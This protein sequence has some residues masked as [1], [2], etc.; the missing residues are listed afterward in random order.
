MAITVT[1]DRMA[2][3]ATRWT[4]S[5]VAVGSTAVVACLL[6]WEL[7]ARGPL[8]DAPF[9]TVVEIV[10]SLLGLLATG[11]FWSSLGQT[12]TTALMGLALAIGAGVVLGVLLG[13]VEFAYR[14]TRL[15]I[16]ILKPIPPIVIMPLV[17][18]LLGPSAEMGVVLVLYG[19]V[20]PILI[21]TV[22]G[23]RDADPV[24]IDTA[25]SFGFGTAQRAVQIVL[26]GAA[27]FIVTGVRIA[28]SAAFVIAVVSE[29]VGGAPGIG[30]ELFVTQNAGLYSEM[31]A[32]VA[33]MGGVGLGFNTAL[34]AFEKWML[35]WHPSVR[36]EVTA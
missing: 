26:P 21:Q 20:W 15:I 16:E 30:H 13:S 36:G 1:R 19:C 28:G 10:R 7:A 5:G 27:A 17:I 6:A 9:P 3:V 24:L 35:H 2:P 18:L 31:Y 32:L 4:G 11:A 33:V 14:S 34:H 22:A 29:L 25:R 12:L 8:A 23:V